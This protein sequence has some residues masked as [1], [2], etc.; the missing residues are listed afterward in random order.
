MKG[1]WPRIAKRAE[2]LSVSDD[3]FHAIEI[4]ARQFRNFNHFELTE[5]DR[6]EI[7]KAAEQYQI[8]ESLQAAALPVKTAITSIQHI[9]KRTKELVW[10]LQHELAGN[11]GIQLHAL[12][13][14]HRCDPDASI[15]ALIALERACAAADKS[16]RAQNGPG[17]EVDIALEKLVCRL[18]ILVETKGYKATAPSLKSSQHRASPFV[19][20]VLGV[21]KVAHPMDRLLQ[22]RSIEDR[23]YGALQR[24]KRAIDGNNA[25]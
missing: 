21:Y 10:T 1:V 13:V 3:T 15:T 7:R 17:R 24:R 16:L 14:L 18:A 22:D 25:C 8:D 2:H 5:A 12:L 6:A 19:E 20:L 4:K 23:I 9:A 11:D